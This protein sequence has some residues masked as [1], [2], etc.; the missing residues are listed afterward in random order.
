M[1]IFVIGS[2]INSKEIEF[3]ARALN[4]ID[5]YIVRYAKP[6][7]EEIDDISYA[8]SQAFNNI[9][10]CDSLYVIKK[11][12]GELGHGTIYEIEYA[13]RLKKEIFYLN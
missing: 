13:R 8:I 6:I 1:K 2:M 11:N 9:E 5:G 7:D 10:W 4:T 12:N 3:S